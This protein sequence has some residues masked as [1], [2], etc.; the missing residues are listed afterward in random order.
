VITRRLPA[1]LL[2]QFLCRAREAP[3]AIALSTMDGDAWSWRA[4]AQVAH[5]VAGALLAAGV[6]AGDRVAILAGNAPVWPLAD[7][8]ILLAGGVSVGTYP[9]AAPAQVQAL[10]ADA[11]AVLAVVGD[12]EQAERLAGVRDTLPALR[13]VVAGP[14]VTPAHGMVGWSEWLAGGR[15]TAS[16]RLEGRALGVDPGDDAVL[17]YTSGSTGMPRGARYTHAGL[18]ASATAIRDVLGLVA[19]DRALSFLPYCHAAERIFGLYTRIAAGMS[20]RL[21]PDLSALSVAAQQYRPT[22]FGGVPRLFEKAAEALTGAPAADR[23]AMLHAHFGPAVRLATSG[24]ARLDDAVH[25]T[26]ATH[27][28][29][30]LQAYGL[31]EHLCVAMQRPGDAAPDH[32]GPPMPGTVLRIAEDGE[33]L[34][35]RGA[36]T[37]AGYHGLPDETRA[38][39]SA[40]GDWLRTGDL[41]EL[42]PTGALRVT[43]RIKDLIAL[44]GGKKV[45]PQRIEALLARDPLVAQAVVFGEGARYLVALLAIDPEALRDWAMRVGVPPDA[46][47]GLDDPRLLA[48]IATT[49]EAANRE[50]SRPEQVKR[51]S[52]LSEVASVADGTLTPTLKPRRAALAARHAT[53][54]GALYA[55][56]DE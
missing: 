45:A 3:D 38:A 12:D 11:G 41:G 19:T 8:G 5:D 51:W 24:G 26:L 18:W 39:F 52:L 16:D 14:G 7:L 50:L 22:L 47:A 46:A 23:R 33:I 27:G 32:V 48:H 36:L 56:G 17:I 21:V 29:P 4:W 53:R 44:A 9:S 13:T 37:F 42:T 6:G 54:L 55:K 31:T 40:D 25:A 43:G 20:A 35:R 30:V 28:L 15:A 1:P 49:V 10:L 34:L 2:D